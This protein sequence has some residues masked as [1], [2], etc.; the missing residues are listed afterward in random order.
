MAAVREEE[1]VEGKVCG[2]VAAV[3]LLTY[4]STSMAKSGISS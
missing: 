2:L 1:E 4:L 3:I